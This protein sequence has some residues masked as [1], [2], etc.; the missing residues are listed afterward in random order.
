MKVVPE[1]NDR[2]KFPVKFCAFQLGRR[3]LLILLAIFVSG[4]TECPPCSF[5]S[6]VVRKVET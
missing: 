5:R 3:F 2:T 6:D 1:S 4:S